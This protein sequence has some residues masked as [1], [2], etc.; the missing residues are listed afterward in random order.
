MRGTVKRLED[1]RSKLDEIGYSLGMASFF[2]A[3]F[4]VFKKEGGHKQ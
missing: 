4:S 2:Q 1:Y 3:C